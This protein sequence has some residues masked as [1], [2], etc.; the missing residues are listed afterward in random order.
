MFLLGH[1]LKRNL[2]SRPTAHLSTTGRLHAAG[3]RPAREQGPRRGVAPQQRRERKGEAARAAH[4]GTKRR[5]EG[6][7]SA[8]AERQQ[9]GHH[10]KGRRLRETG[11]KKNGFP[12]GWPNCW[13]DLNRFVLS[14]VS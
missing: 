1:S 3:R 9:R 8:P 10:V 14:M 4:R 7:R 12:V 11:R 2:F 13:A 6:G 5:R